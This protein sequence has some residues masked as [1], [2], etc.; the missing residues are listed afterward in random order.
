MPE[1]GPRSVLE[2]IRY[3]NRISIF[4]FY[5]GAL[6]SAEKKEGMAISSDFKKPV[7]I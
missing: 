6:E 5:W 4:Y 1:I 7:F 3:Y 2:P